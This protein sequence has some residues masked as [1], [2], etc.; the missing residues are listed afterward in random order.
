MVIVEP[1]VCEPGRPT[2]GG[3]GHMHVTSRPGFSARARK[4]FIDF[5]I[6]LN[7]SKLTHR[8]VGLRSTARSSHRK[9]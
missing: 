7:I 3:K 9:Y 1:Y 4:G 6:W 2:W 5:G 8:V